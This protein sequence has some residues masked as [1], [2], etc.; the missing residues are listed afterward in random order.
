MI[1]NSSITPTITPATR[2]VKPDPP[3]P[4]SL[5]RS[6]WRSSFDFASSSTVVLPTPACSSRTIITAWRTTVSSLSMSPGD[7]ALRPAYR[8]RLPASVLS[9]STRYPVSDLGFITSLT[10][11]D[12]AAGSCA[13]ERAETNGPDTVSLVELSGRSAVAT[14]SPT[15]APVASRMR[16]CRRF[17][18]VPPRVAMYAGTRMAPAIRTGTSSVATMKE[19]ERTRSRYSRLATIR[20][21]LAMAGHP[22]F[23]AGHADALDEDLVER[24]LHE[25]EPLDP[26]A[27]G[28]QPVQQRLRVGL[29]CE[30]QLEVVVRVVDLVHEL[31]VVQ[32]LAYAVLRAADQRER[33]V[34][35]ARLLL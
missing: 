30:L 26:R 8:A 9:S 35:R 2:P 1:A 10:A 19:R 24:R 5:N 11:I 4:L 14:R 27:G 7:D 22:R 3:R 29:R 13:A 28:D 34:S 33:H 31:P 15:P 17:D 23:D 18:D 16:M 12:S 25:L 21:L 32:H 20:I 6:L